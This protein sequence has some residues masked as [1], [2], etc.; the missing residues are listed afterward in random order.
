M[1]AEWEYGANGMSDV[2]DWSSNS[3]H[4]KIE[5]LYGVGYAV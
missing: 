5:R 1:Y 4:L 3:A 2:M